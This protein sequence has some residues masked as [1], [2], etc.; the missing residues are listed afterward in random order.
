M[1]TIIFV[2][3]MTAVVTGSVIAAFA[4]KAQDEYEM[5]KLF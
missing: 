1:T 3:A 5:G 2:L 4:Y